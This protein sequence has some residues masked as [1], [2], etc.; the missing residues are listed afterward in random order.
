MSQKFKT[1]LTNAGV[2]KLAAGLPP[3]GKKVIFTTMAV[4]D[5]GGSLPEPKPEQTALV[6]EVWRALINTITPHPKYANC[7]VAELIIP[8]E[9]GGFWTRELGLYDSEGVLIAVANMAESYKPLLAEGSGRA[10]TVCMVIA[11]SNMASVEL[12]VDS[13]T[14]IATK[15]Y[16]DDAL[17]KHAKSRNHPDG[18]LKEKGF[19]QLSSAT[20]SDSET[21]AATPKA[22]KAAVDVGNA[23][24]QNA[25][26]RLL[27][28]SN[29]SDVPDKV[30]ARK[31]MGLGTAAQMDASNFL[32]PWNNLW[33]VQDKSAARLNLGLGT[34]SQLP[35]EAFLMPGKNLS[36]VNDKAQA[37]R[38]LN[39][40]AKSQKVNGHA[41]E[42]DNTNVTSQDIFDGQAINIP[43][44]AD[45][46]SYTT[47]GLYLQPAN[48]NAIAGKNYP[49]A[50]A[51]SLEIYKNAG[52]TQVYRVYLSSRSYVRSFY[53]GVWTAWAM[54]Y[55]KDNKPT[56]QEIGAVPTTGG[57][58]G[59]L[60]NAEHYSTKQ[61]VWPG[62]GSFQNQIKDPRA[63]FYSAG[64]TADGNLFLPMTKAAVN[65]QGKGYKASISYGV[66]TSGKADFPS[67][68]IHILS[69]LGNGT[70]RDNTW[71]FN[72]NDGSFISSGAVHAGYNVVAGSG[73]YESGGTVRVY[74]PNNPQPI[75]TSWIAGTQ[76]VMD[77]F[78]QRST[79]GLAQ[80][81][82]HRDWSTGL[83]TQWGFTNNASGLQ[84]IYFPI[85]FPNSCFSIQATPYT[86]GVIGTVTSVVMGF[87]N[88]S[89]T[90]NAS[91]P[92]PVFW[93]AKGY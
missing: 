33:D 27:R 92:I 1:I 93:E 56:P 20:D 19:V 41:L 25:E 49:E 55:D 13:S 63:L 38:T 31:N 80:S 62:A 71:M 11:V 9:V 48:A 57:S 81:G 8:P 52:I 76:W 7:V 51:G 65:T 12:Q 10:Q 84:T 39:G 87:N 64:F 58:V 50:N 45:L 82:W 67:A 77:Y 42:G 21:F 61:N 16:V 34:A 29:L 54:Q 91:Q 28:D 44:V 36:D 37:L 60:D 35:A 5:G 40:V 6:R 79:A 73:V 18:T 47:P 68:C 46:N 72:P 30:A 66:L 2:Q 24:N 89:A 75:D 26:K 15:E 59:Y 3:D 70:F 83:I 53:A 85:A 32:T 22:I 78:A 4:G 43:E 88:S 17:D 23:A 86:S 14:V 69:D 74:S 90:F